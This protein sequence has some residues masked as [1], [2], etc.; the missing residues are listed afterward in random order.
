MLS[1]CA[2]LAAGA[3]LPG[4]FR[5]LRGRYHSSS[6]TTLPDWLERAKRIS[7]TDSVHD[8]SAFARLLLLGF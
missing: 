5:N 4:T 3:A 2:L 7:E 8:P 1:A 6:P